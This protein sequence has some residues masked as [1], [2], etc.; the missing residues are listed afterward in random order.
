MRFARAT[1]VE[2]S[3]DAEVRVFECAACGHEFRIAVWADAAD[4]AGVPGGL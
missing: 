4:P 2:N 3:A 1:K